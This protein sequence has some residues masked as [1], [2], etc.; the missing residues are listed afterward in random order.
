MMK[1]TQR[2][3]ESGSLHVRRGAPAKGE[4]SARERI[5]ATASRL[6]YREG[7]RAVGVDTI[8]AESGVSKT[9]LYRSFA[10]KDD[11]IAAFAREQDQ[12]LWAW[13]DRV[14]ARYPGDPAAQLSG[15][16]AGIAKL[17]TRPDFRGCP[18]I[19]L[20]TEFPSADHPGHMLARRNKQ[21][22]R[23]RLAALTAALGAPQP[24]RAAARIAL[25]IDGAFASA[26]L[27]DKANLEADLKK[28]ALA[29]IAP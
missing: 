12:L 4:A 3:D 29:V 15:L 14:A 5:L 10:S 27:A 26:S 6:F 24:D 7:V 17:V 2:P 19:N 28:A 8:V 22:L 25:I 9:S 20:A 18:F 11:L 1:Q 13:W 23:Q 16:L 21:E